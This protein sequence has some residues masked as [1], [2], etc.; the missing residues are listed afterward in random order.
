MIF[1]RAES[2]PASAHRS[3]SSRTRA[4]RLE[5]YI[6]F[7]QPLSRLVDTFRACSTLLQGE[8]LPGYHAAAWRLAGLPASMS[9]RPH[10]GVGKLHVAAGEPA[11]QRTAAW[12]LATHLLPMHVAPTWGPA[13]ST[14]PQGE[15]LPGTAQHRGASRAYPLR[16]HVA[17]T[18]GPASSTSPQSE[19]LPGTAQH[20]DASQNRLLRCRV[21]PTW[22]PTN[23]TSAQCSRGLYPEASSAWRAFDI[24]DC[25]DNAGLDACSENFSLFFIYSSSPI[26]TWCERQGC[27]RWQRGR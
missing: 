19:R 25:A 7:P 1:W 23:S 9:R 24:D 13:S 20:C 8:R 11:W 21:A 26:G 2:E 17:P 14:S 10:V 12:R 18:W 5:R 4:C 3:R 15:R 16:C 6:E 27:G 22:G